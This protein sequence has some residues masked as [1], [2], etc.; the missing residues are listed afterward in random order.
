MARWKD[1]LKGGRGDYYTPAEFDKEALRAGVA[2]E[3]EHTHDRHIATEIA[4]DHLT[5]DPSY[6]DKLER[7]EAGEFGSADGGDG[8][9]LLWVGLAGG[10]GL[11][12]YWYSRRGAS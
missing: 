5:E 9:L 3:L 10:L 6:Y 11:L 4:M 2:H 1:K 12:W 7:M 8:N